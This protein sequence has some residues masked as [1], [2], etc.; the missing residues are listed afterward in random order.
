MFGKQL[1]LECKSSN[2][3]LRRLR[4][5]INHLFEDKLNSDKKFIANFKD[6]ILKLAKKYVK[7]KDL[8]LQING[9]LQ[10]VKKIILNLN[11]IK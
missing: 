10:I 9:N 7:E 11:G 2:K 8:W 5:K 4:H 6:T 3:N 1:K